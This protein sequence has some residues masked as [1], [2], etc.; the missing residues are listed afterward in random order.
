MTEETRNVSDAI[1]AAKHGDTI[2]TIVLGPH[3]AHGLRAEV[4]L[5]VNAAHI[6]TDLGQYSKETAQD[7]ANPSRVLISGRAA[8]I[9]AT[10]ERGVRR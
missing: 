3:G 1:R 4:V 6:R 10:V 7:A 2:H 9:H 5:G 8:R